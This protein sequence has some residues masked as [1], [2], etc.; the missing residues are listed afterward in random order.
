MDNNE[1]KLRRYLNLVTADLVQARKRSEELERRIGEPIAIVGMACRYPGGVRSPEDLWELAITGRDAITPFPRDRGWDLDSLYDPDPNHPGTSYTQQGGFLTDVA[2]FD[3]QFWGISPREATAMDPQQRLLLETSW[4]ALERARINPHSLHGSETGVFVGPSVTDY[5]ALL[6]RYPT[7]F[8]GLLLGGLAGAIISG[9]ISYLLGLEGPAVTVDTGCSS[10]LTA[11]HLAAGA[12][13]AGDC[14]LAL[15]GG[16]SVLATPG[17]FVEFSTQR[18]LAPD[19]RCKSFGDAADGTSWAEGVGMVVVERLSDARR[20]RH[21]VLAVLRG[22]AINQDGAS[23]GLTAPSGPSQQR[24]IRRALAAAGLKPSDVDAVEAHGTGTTLGD[25]IEAQAL[26]ATYG[27]DRLPGRPLFL[28]SLKSNLGHSQSAAGVGGL[29]KT[30]MSLRHGML[31]PTLHADPP[32]TEVDWTAGDIELLQE[33]RSW[34]ETEDRPRR[35]AV[36]AFGIGGTNAHV[37]LE[38]VSEEDAGREGDGIAHRTLTA[39]PWL[40]SGRTAAAMRAQAARL[41]A[42]LTNRAEPADPTDVGYSL[43]TTRAALDN[44]GVVVA[45]D[46][47]GLLTG[48]RALAEGRPHAAVTTGA[49][50][51]GRLAFLFTGQG[52]QKP[53]MGRELYAEHPV[54]AEAFDA[55]CA[56]LDGPIGRSLRDLTFTEDDPLGL[57]DRT[58]FAQPALFAVETALF[59]LVES[60]GVRPDFV[61]GHSVGEVTAAHVA[62]ILSLEDACALVAARARL[63]QSMPP[64]GAMVAVRAAEEDILPMLDQLTGLVSV[65]AV[66]GPTSVVL[67]GDEKTLTTVMARLTDKGL[68]PRELRVSHAFHS[69]RIDPI[70]ADFRSAIES[71]SYA[72]PRIP[73]VPLAPG[74]ADRGER[75]RSADYWVA[76]A[77]AAVRFHDGVVRLSEAGVTTYLELGP[78]GVLAALGQDCLPPAGPGVPER[79]FVPT[80]RQGRAEPAA[81][82]D[83]VAA[84]FVRGVRVD[85]RAVY[86]G[87]G[88]A[89]LDLPTYAFQRRR[90]WLVDHLPTGASLLADQ[91]VVGGTGAP[92]PDAVMAETVTEIPSVRGKMADRP[93]QEWAEIL[94]AEVR[95]QVAQLMGYDAFEDV[96]PQRG[97]AEL[98]FDSLTAAWLTERLR[99][100]TGLELSRALVIDCPTPHAVATHLADRFAVLEDLETPPAAPAATPARPTP[101]TTEPLPVLFAQ[102]CARNQVKDGLELLAVAARMRVGTGSP[103]MR[104]PVSFSQ[105]LAGPTLVCIPSVVAPSNVYQYARMADTLRTTH[106]MAVLPLTGYAD[107]ESLPPSRTDLVAAVSETVLANVTGPYVLVGYSSGGWIAHA[108]AARLK[109]LN[110]A[111][112][113]LVLLDS[114]LPGSTGLADIQ[115]DLLGDAYAEWTA[116]QPLRGAELTAMAHHLQLFDDWAPTDIDGVPTLL[117]RAT[118]RMGGRPP[119]GEHWQAHWG[120]DHDAIDVPGTHLSII[121]EHAASTA[122]AISGWL[123]RR[124]THP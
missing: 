121:D 98:G 94:L 99:A 17:S 84:L 57:L 43:A 106:N 104:E 93:R 15:A 27:R 54:F 67:S 58:G 69:P 101:P 32:S 9:R 53:G 73:I 16:V 88:A 79:A 114:H 19:G 110:T 42:F 36:S 6:A 83:A 107:H 41:A 124:P 28:G 39:V 70:L 55:V 61:A 77:R 68:H 92:P 21:P 66:N 37:I 47:D 80:L 13:R 31:A 91:G 109:D 119:T 5:A 123:A 48:V 38:A 87:T 12:L 112:E 3:A 25:P 62:G 100:V 18:G 76:Q 51:R 50:A 74:D 120:P 29:I 33:P 72:A 75:M 52:A 2:D 116:T 122:S 22:S 26:L 40:V 35:A 96:N 46:R 78:G 82:L 4:Q 24:V 34:P 60:W 115:V 102:A 108:A 23:N 111:P 71:I 97:F 14:S 81:L 85:W 64:G 56:H 30:V 86:A 113:S 117:L 20:H 59:R 1:H 44:R 49:T 103:K 65:A 105:G 8:E 45:A 7:G 95:D 10:S 63:M 89:Q 11:L 118:E 90:Y